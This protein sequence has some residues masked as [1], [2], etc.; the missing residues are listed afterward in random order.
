MSEILLVNSNDKYLFIFGSVI[1]TLFTLYKSYD[2]YKFRTS[3]NIRYKSYLSEINFQPENK[4]KDNERVSI[5]GGP[6]YED[7]FGEE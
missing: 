5:K 2:I 6:T 4:I 7:I 1:V 3:E